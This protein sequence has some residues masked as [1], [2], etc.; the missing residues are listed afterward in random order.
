MAGF[1]VD[2]EAYYTTSRSSAWNRWDYMY[3]SPFAYPYDYY[4]I[5]L[6]ILHGGGAV[7]VAVTRRYDIMQITWRFFHLT[8]KVILNGAIS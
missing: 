7:A 1:L 4:F 5:R 6:I 2:A 8:I 3:G